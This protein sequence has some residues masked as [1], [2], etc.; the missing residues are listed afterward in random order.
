MM[1]TPPHFVAFFIIACSFVRI[2]RHNQT[3]A[4]LIHSSD[5]VF[6]LKAKIAAAYNQHKNS[7]NNN[8]ND[9]KKNDD[10]DDDSM[11]PDDL[12]LLVSSDGT[13]LMEENDD[14]SITTLAQCTGLK[15]DGE[16]ILYVVR[17][18][19]DN[20]WEPVDVVSTEQL[21]EDPMVTTASN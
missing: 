18:I 7:C 15:R 14:Q 13:V 9:I 11:T 8:G 17:R 10:N 21:L 2:K 6:S 16:D 3:F 4:F 19:S 5:T 12:Q 20:E 1:L